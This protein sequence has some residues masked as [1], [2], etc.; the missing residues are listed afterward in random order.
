[1]AFWS[2]AQCQPAPGRDR[3]AVRCLAL[4]GFEAYQPQLC[5]QRTVRGRRVVVR[6]PLFPCYL[7]IRIETRWYPICSTPGI[8]RLIRA[9]DCPARVPDHIID[10]IRSRERKGVVVLPSQFKRGDPVR[11]LRG[12]FRQQLALYDGQ[13][14]HERVA[15]L[16]ALLGASVRVELSRTD[17][18][19]V[20]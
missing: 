1:M 13:A 16:L 5:E 19:R 2:V 4:G 20:P 14:P 7:F 11:V 6:R 3:I 17:I 12:P 15:V 8:T 18:E 9:G 10:A